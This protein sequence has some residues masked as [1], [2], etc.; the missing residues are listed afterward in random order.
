[1]A[2]LLAAIKSNGLDFSLRESIKRMFSPLFPD[3]KI[4]SNSLQ[5]R[6]EQF[7]KQNTSTIVI[8]AKVILTPL[9]EILF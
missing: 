2:H 4:F 5:N 7:W 9:T 3:S 8:G 6:S 1:M